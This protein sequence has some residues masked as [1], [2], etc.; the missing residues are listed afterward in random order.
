MCILRYVT[1]CM[2]SNETSQTF[3]DTATILRAHIWH[4]CNTRTWR[5]TIKYGALWQECL[6]TGVQVH[7]RVCV[8]L[9]DRVDK[10]LDI[11]KLRGRPCLTY[12]SLREPHMDAIHVSKPPLCVSRAPRTPTW[13]PTAAWPQMGRG[14]VPLCV[15][16][17]SK[18]DANTKPNVRLSWHYNRAGPHYMNPRHPQPNHNTNKTYIRHKYTNISPR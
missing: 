13:S 5:T 16:E 6:L 2:W 1:L 12:I 4:R 3:F 7:C 8:K 10:H 14:H 15:V 17:L 11:G 9:L 18:H